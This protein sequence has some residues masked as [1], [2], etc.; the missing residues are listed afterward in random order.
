MKKVD[1][2]RSRRGWRPVGGV[3]LGTASLVVFYCLDHGISIACLTDPFS[4]TMFG[5]VCLLLAILMLWER[6]SLRKE[7]DPQWRTVCQVLG[8]D[9]E[10]DGAVLKG[11]WEGRPFRAVAY[12]LS[13]T[14]YSA[15]VEEY[16]VIM[17]SERP[18]PAWKLTRMYGSKCS[19][20]QP[21]WKLRA[22]RSSTEER[23]I[24]AG[25]L[26]AVQEA[27]SHLHNDAV[28]SYDPRDNNVVYKNSRGEVPSA[29]DFAAHLRMVRRAVDIQG[30]A[31]ES[32]AAT[33]DESKNWSGTLRP[34]LRAGRPP[35]WV[36]CL[37]LPASIVGS[38]ASDRWPWT[39]A[40][41]PLALV[42]PL[43]CRIRV[44][45][46]RLPQSRPSTTARWY[47]TYP[48]PDN[49]ATDRGGNPSGNA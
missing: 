22:D 44:G 3:V 49:A 16:T 48:A 29:E 40:L 26:Q 30:V 35:V 43:A 38:T 31:V 47:G 42:A 46:R 41:L 9:H 39:F 11:T 2:S 5:M 7:Y 8:D 13:G 14:Q 23:L 4:W 25:L 1:G 33:D 20:Q 21:T 6:R 19:R 24:D 17:V 34:R 10:H 45:R 27:D 15:S 36:M 12:H 37:W 32:A 18:G 28:L